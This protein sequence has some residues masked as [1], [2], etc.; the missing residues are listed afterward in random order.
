MN[1]ASLELSKELYE[2]SGWKSDFLMYIKSASGWVVMNQH[3][4][5][6]YRA[7]SGKPGHFVS[8]DAYDLGYLLRKLP[9][10]YDKDRVKGPM[11]AFLLQLQPSPVSTNWQAFYRYE[12]KN[13]NGY[14][15]EVTLK[16]EAGTPEDAAAKLAIE[17]FK[18]GVLTRDGDD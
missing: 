3:Q 17:L 5:H 12:N 6:N 2:L 15:S 18:Q 10:W 14:E 11:H 9:R 4:Y 16:V 13:P 7:A 8:V 1:V